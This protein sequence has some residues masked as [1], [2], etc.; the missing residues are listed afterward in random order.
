MFRRAK[1]S[2]TEEVSVLETVDQIVECIFGLSDTE[3]IDALIRHKLA[4]GGSRSEK[5]RR[6][7]RLL[8]L[9]RGFSD[10]C[11]VSDLASNATQGSRD[12]LRGLEAHK[13]VDNHTEIP[14]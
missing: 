14:V 8:L 6:L 5:C 1:M 4:V 7:K 3:L 9:Y 11:S 13:D 12:D 2:L 10:R